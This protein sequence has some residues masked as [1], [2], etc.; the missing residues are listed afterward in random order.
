MGSFAER[1]GPVSV[2]GLDSAIFIYLIDENPTY[3]GLSHELFS[4]IERGERAGVTSAITLM[5]IIVRPLSL[6]KED[7]AR[8]YEAFLVNFPNLTMADIDRDVIRGAARLRARYRIRPPDALQFS[9][10]LLYGAQAFI[11]NDRHFERLKDELD[12]ILLDDYLNP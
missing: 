2:V 7:V 12:V 4:G 10:S 5:E 6:G 1:I 11:T 8:K 9:A 3:Q